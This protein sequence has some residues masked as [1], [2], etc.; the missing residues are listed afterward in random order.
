MSRSLRYIAIAMLPPR[1]AFGGNSGSP[2][3]PPP[4]PPL[5]P[6]PS[7]QSPQGAQA[8]DDAR[9]RAQAAFGAG[10]TIMTTPQGATAPAQLDRKQ[11]LGG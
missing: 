9:R 10:G 7:L 11:L 2:T 5:A 6:P 1:L 4:P 8:S 3:P